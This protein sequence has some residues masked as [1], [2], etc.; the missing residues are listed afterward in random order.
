MRLFIAIDLPGATRDRIEA[1]ISELRRE[2]PDV[3]WAGIDGIHLTLKFLGEVGENRLPALA[4]IL[5]RRAAALSGGFT[6][7][8][9]GVGTFGGTSR[10]RVAW[11]GVVDPEGALARLAA[12]VEEGCAG[13]GFPREGRPFH[14]H[15]TLA[16]IKVASRGLA[17]ALAARADLDL[18]GFEV[19]SYHLFQ[20]RLQSG[21]AKYLR[22]AECRLGGPVAAPS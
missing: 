10:P 4:Q 1:L 13:L 18:G 14:P 11:C 9:R 8:V 21:G 5:G 22:L 7:G 12:D 15:L 20:S 2:V 16:R 19:T 3:R 17:P 6:V